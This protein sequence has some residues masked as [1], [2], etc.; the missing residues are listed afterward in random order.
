MELMSRFP[1]I[2][3]DEALMEEHPGK[4]LAQRSAE[5]LYLY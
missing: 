1:D 2:E 3:G 5:A 4:R